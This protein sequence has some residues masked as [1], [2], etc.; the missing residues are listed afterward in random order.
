MSTKL[1][2]KKA[3]TTTKEKDI[4]DDTQQNEPS[5]SP[6][7]EGDME[8][9][10]ITRHQT[11][12]TDS[13]MTILEMMERK[14]SDKEEKWHEEER[15]RRVE[16]HEKEEQRREEEKREERR[17][18]IYR[19]KAE[20]REMRLQELLESRDKANVENQLR[21]FE[22]NMKL[23]SVPTWKDNDTP[24]DYL[25][26]FEH[27]ILSNEEPKDQWAR[28]LSIYLS[29]KASAV[30]FSSIPTDKQNDYEVVKT[31]LLDAFGD[32]VDM[33]RQLWWTLRKTA[34][35]SLQ[36]CMIR[37]EQKFKRGLEGCSTYF[38]YSTT[39]FLS[40]FTSLLSADCKTYVLGRNSKD[41]MAAAH[42]ADKFYRVNP[43]KPRSS[44]SLQVESKD[45]DYSGKP[46]VKKDWIRSEQLSADQSRCLA[47]TGCQTTI[48]QRRAGI[49]R[50]T[51]ME[52]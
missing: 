16:E 46:N 42:L 3:I 15:C 39:L 9:L 31:V 43:W 22:K 17:E 40:K 2:P 26:R 14:N 20:K 41:G 34:D 47:K 12:L 10:P 50:I 27:V 6:S 28:T 21:L 33:A 35:E 7:E 44:F 32:T 36:D 45:N 30:F 4:L 19:E 13:L 48:S 8:H 49:G 11:A 18:W 38:D 51:L 23:R 1:A 37:I 25:H 52:E 29:G 5:A 24:A